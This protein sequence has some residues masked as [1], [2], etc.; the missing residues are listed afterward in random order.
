MKR[1]P[2]LVVNLKKAKTGV[3]QSE[4]SVQCMQ[5][6]WHWIAHGS[7]TGEVLDSACTM[8]EVTWLMCQNQASE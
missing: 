5:S 1:D 3:V 2:V 4:N 6:V 8:A 7:S